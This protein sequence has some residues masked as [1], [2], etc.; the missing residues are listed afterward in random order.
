MKVVTNHKKKKKQTRRKSFSCLKIGGTSIVSSH[1]PKRQPKLPPAPSLDYKC[2]AAGY[3]RLRQLI[4]WRQSS[5]PL[6]KR[7]ALVYRW[8]QENHAVSSGLF[9]AN[10]PIRRLGLLWSVLPDRSTLPTLQWVKDIMWHV[11]VSW[12]AEF[13]R[14]HHAGVPH[15]TVPVGLC[16]DLCAGFPGQHPRLLHFL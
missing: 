6:R 16:R 7:W 2:R 1:H 12:L 13:D 15:R 11:S 9:Q 3:C 14:G 4:I 10:D 8:G 5:K